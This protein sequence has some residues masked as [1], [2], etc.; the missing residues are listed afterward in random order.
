MK[1]F[2]STDDEQ[3]RFNEFMNRKQDS[4]NDS[5]QGN[6]SRLPDELF[7]FNWGALMLNFIWGLSMRIPWTWLHVVP[8]VGMIMP[9]V[10]WIR[11]NEWAWKY[12]RW[13]SI[14]HFKQVQG[15]WLTAGIIFTVL[16]FIV[17]MAV[18]SWVESMMMKLINGM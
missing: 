14:E 4:D 9:F 8:I 5:G 2:K 3:A 11:G 7:G 12:R 17:S 1:G 6:D 18:M 16:S 15:K 13:D 10:M